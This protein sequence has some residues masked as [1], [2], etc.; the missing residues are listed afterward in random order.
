MQS[1]LKGQM[2]AVVC[3]LGFMKDQEL[4]QFIAQQ[5]GLKI[6]DVEGM[7]IPENLVKLISRN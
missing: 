4:T 1:V 2:T 3:K 7:V 5:E 6:A